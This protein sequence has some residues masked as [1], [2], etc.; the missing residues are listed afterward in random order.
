MT[1]DCIMVNHRQRLG[2]WGE[3]AAVTFLQERGYVVLARNFRTP[4]GELD[5]IASRDSVLVFVEVKARSSNRH[6]FPE[7]AVSHRKQAH[8]LAAAES[9]FS[10]TNVD[11]FAWQFDIIAITLQPGQPPEIEHI[12]NVIT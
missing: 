9:Y 6:G 4:H 10:V 3:A 1:Y 7:Q 12:E 5:I 2:A 8:M 11:F